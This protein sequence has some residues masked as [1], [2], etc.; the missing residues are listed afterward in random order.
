MCMAILEIKATFYRLEAIKRKCLHF[1]VYVCTILYSILVYVRHIY[2]TVS[3]VH[4][5][6]VPAFRGVEQLIEC[7][8]LCISP[9][10]DL[11]CLSFS[12]L[13]M[14]LYLP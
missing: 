8:P 14:C 13:C 4:I 9:S 1:L 3:T 12:Y 10:E 5:N 11:I 2:Q 6:P 7:V